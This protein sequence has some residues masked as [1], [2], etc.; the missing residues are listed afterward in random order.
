MKITVIFH[1]F[2]KCYCNKN[3][4]GT[5]AYL[6]CNTYAVMTRKLAW[7]RSLRRPRHK[8]EDSNKTE[9]KKIGC[10]YVNWTA[11]AQDWIQEQA[12]VNMVMNHKTVEN[13]LIN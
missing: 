6:K 12:F 9:F 10:E 8:Q 3:I 7:K 13:F 1:I 2:I 5:V 11:P 4:R